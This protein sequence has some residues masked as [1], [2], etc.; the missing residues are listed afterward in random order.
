MKL[1]I[2]LGV[3]L[4]LCSFAGAKQKDFTILD[5]QRIRAQIEHGAPMLIEQDGVKIETAMLGTHAGGLTFNFS[6]L[7]ELSLTNV[8]V[9]DVTDQ[10]AVAVVTDAAPALENQ[11]WSGVSQPSAISKESCPWMFA[12]EDSP[13]V[14]RFTLTV[15]NR[16]K[17]I[18]IYQAAIYD[19]AMKE[20]IVESA[21]RKK[22]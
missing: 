1:S 5:G 7:T 15:A 18:V 4:S 14:F 3:F 8:V 16:K 9:E 21:Q 17:P 12:A 22:H 13:R 11:R 20:I 10:T 6:L 2:L 19:A